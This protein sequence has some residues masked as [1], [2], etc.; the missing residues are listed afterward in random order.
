ME[1]SDY[2]LLNVSAL[3]GV[4]TNKLKIPLMITLVTR[5]LPGD[6]YENMIH[7]LS[8]RLPY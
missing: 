2:L 4:F 3:V 7:T 5:F 8:A 1:R 6:R